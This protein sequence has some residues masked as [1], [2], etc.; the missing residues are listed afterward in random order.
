M[1]IDLVKE[2][3]YSDA[4]FIANFTR[5][6]GLTQVGVYDWLCAFNLMLAYIPG[7]GSKMEKDYRYHFG[8][9]LKVTQS[10]KRS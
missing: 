2:K 4:E 9:W 8:N 5:N 3:V 10:R 6:W 7:K 1:D